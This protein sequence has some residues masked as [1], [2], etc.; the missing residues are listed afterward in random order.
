MHNLCFDEKHN[1]A[2]AH[3]PHEEANGWWTRPAGLTPQTRTAF[4]S[5]RKED[6]RTGL[7]EKKKMRLA[8]IRSGFLALTV[9]PAEREAAVSPGP[10]RTRHAERITLPSVDSPPHRDR[11]RAS[12]RNPHHTA[13]RGPRKSSRGRA[14][15]PSTLGSYRSF[16]SP[17]STREE[18]K[19]K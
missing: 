1:W 17:S 12:E 18:E 11:E 13:R 9:Y 16:S 6:A 15:S 7:L 5:R 4:I 10:T 8:G 2:S 3:G 19:I 14:T